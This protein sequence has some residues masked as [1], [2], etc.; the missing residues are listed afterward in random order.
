[1]M[2][3]PF[4]FFFFSLNCLGQVYEELGVKLS[5]KDSIVLIENLDQKFKYLKFVE[6]EFGTL[7]EIEL[8]RNYDFEGDV[9]HCH[10]LYT[11][12]GDVFVDIVFE[13]QKRKIV[14]KRAKRLNNK[15]KF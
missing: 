15:I 3:L 5:L 13:R 1:M 2:K 11:K 8:I 10:K 4:L 9:V 6:R 12:N 7:G 14:F